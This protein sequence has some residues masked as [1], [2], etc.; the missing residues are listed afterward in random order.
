MSEFSVA[1]LDILFFEI[2]SYVHPVGESFVHHTQIYIMKIRVS[3][4]PAESELL[5]CGECKVFVYIDADNF[6]LPVFQIS[7]SGTG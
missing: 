5:G 3:V 6:F 4:M 1:V 2:K 7:V